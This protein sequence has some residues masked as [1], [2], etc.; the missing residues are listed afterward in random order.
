MPAARQRSR[1]PVMA[2][3]VIATMRMCRPVSPLA[4]ANRDGRVEAAHDRHLQVHQHQ[5]EGF[6]TL[7]GGERLE[8]VVRDD[9]DVTSSASTDRRRPLIHD[10]V[11]GQQD[12]PC[13]ESDR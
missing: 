4:Q 5:V 3:A 9:N 13:P 11:F 8:A 10:V 12:G 2:C 1:S 7:E 6:L